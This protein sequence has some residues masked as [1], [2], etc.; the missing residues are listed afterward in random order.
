MQMAEKKVWV[1]L[2][3][4]RDHPDF[5]SRTGEASC[6]S[7]ARAFRALDLNVACGS[8]TTWRKTRL[9]DNSPE[10]RCSGMKNT[11]PLA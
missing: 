5:R 10:E 3:L 8:G 6:R 1:Q 7:R 11:D 4:G 2:I 9:A